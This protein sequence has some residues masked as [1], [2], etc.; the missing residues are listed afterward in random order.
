MMGYFEKV[1]DGLESET[2]LHSV[3]EVQERM[4]EHENGQTV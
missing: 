2:V 1:C 3:K 4:A